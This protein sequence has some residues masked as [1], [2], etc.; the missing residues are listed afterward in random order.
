MLPPKKL[1]HIDTHVVQTHAAN[2]VTLAV[3]VQFL[4]I[5]FFACPLSF[6]VLNISFDR[7]SFFR[8]HMQT[9][10]EAGLPGPRLAVRT[11]SPTPISDIFNLIFVK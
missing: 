3:S 2:T 9:N 6:S 4:L 7:D 11:P 5:L 1:S 10:G 8:K